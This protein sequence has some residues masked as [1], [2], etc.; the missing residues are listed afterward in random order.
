MV[1][2]VDDSI[3]TLKEQYLAL[4]ATYEELRD[5]P[6][7]NVAQAQQWHDDALAFMV[8]MHDNMVIPLKDGVEDLLE[9]RAFLERVH[10][11]EIDGDSNQIHLERM[12]IRPLIQNGR[13]V[14]TAIRNWVAAHSDDPG[15]RQK[16]I[17][18]LNELDGV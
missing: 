17:D 6:I 7:G 9:L 13:G 4:R 1:R 8:D 14:T 12:A 11:A 18:K 10:S 3:R 5:R 2:L 15:W 16:I